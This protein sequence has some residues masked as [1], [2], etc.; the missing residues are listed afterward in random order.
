MLPNKKDDILLVPVSFASD[1]FTVE[2]ST[3][4]PWQQCMLVNG[5]DDMQFDPGRRVEGRGR[6]N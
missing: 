5:Q 6:S 4:L 1:T 2:I 3:P